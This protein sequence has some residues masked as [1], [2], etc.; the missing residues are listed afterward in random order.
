MNYYCKLLLLCVLSFGSIVAQE[1][2]HEVVPPEILFKKNTQSD[3][4]ISPDGKYFAEQI[5]EDGQYSLIIVDIDEYKMVHR[6]MM[7]FEVDRLF[8]LTS[9]RILYESRG[10]IFATDIDGMNRMVI[11]DKTKK[12]KYLRGYRRYRY[13][14]IIGGNPDNPNEIIV[15]TVGFEGNASIKN[16]NVY[17]GAAELVED[18]DEDDIQ[19]WITDSRGKARL[20]L[21]VGRDESLTFLRR[22]ADSDRWRP[23]EVKIDDQ[24]YPLQIEGDSFLNQD[25]IFEGFSKEAD[26]AYIT[27]NVNSD[28]RKLITYDI[29][30]EEVI[31]VLLEDVLCDVMDPMGADVHMIYDYANYELAG[32]R[33]EGMTP[34]FKWFSPIFRNVQNAL[35]E[36]Y[37]GFIH[38]IID[39]DGEND[40]FVIMQWN[41]V[42][43]GNVGIWDR[44][45]QTYSVM[46]HMNEELNNYTLSRTKN[47][48]VETRD[49]YKLLSYLNEPINLKENSAAPLV[50]IPH[51]GPWARDYWDM[52][53]YCQYF[54]TRGYYTL[55]VNFRGSTGFGK[56]HTL[57]GI[58]NMD[59]VM[60]NDIADAVSQVSS[61]YNIDRDRVFI[62]GHSY[63]GYATY[64]SLLRYPHLY[65][66][67][68]AIAAPSDIKQ[69]MKE[70]KRN[71]EAFAYKF[72]ETALGSNDKQY[73]KKISPINYVDKI[74][75]PLMIVHGR[76]DKIIPFDQSE[77]MVEALKDAG[78]KVNFEPVMREGHT[79]QDANTLG[80]ILQQAIILFENT[81]HANKK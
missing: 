24:Y 41:D 57:A 9:N 33:Y 2:A 81:T 58:N 77:A 65:A 10:A 3:F 62:L 46:F 51:G 59:G 5:Y 8:W 64:M 63:G 18:G 50:V 72:W 79:I 45:D 48:I 61:Q 75:K 53:R 66:A 32:L 74:D 43:A 54:S 1:L 37:P 31:E 70:T 55:R 49:D 22:A 40:R 44:S 80:Y 39:S 21:Q 76:R 4:T 56:A 19:G 25:L 30:K 27:S 47:V 28:K 26:V 6:V 11:A 67:G 52:D 29:K 36:K 12:D 68:V 71:K 16:I 78:K 23:F 14:K 20:A 42:N 35:N 13:N 34:Q 15:Q 69:W 60:I 7:L 38:E 17:T 73:L